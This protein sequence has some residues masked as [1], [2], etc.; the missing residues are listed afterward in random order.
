ML[1]LSCLLSTFGL[2]YNGIKRIRCYSRL[3][4]APLRDRSCASRTPANCTESNISLLVHGAQT[5]I[6]FPFLEQL[7][8]QK[9]YKIPCGSTLDRINSWY[10][11]QL[12]RAGFKDYL[13][14]SCARNLGAG[15]RYV[16]F[17][18]KVK[19]MIREALA[20]QTVVS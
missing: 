6:T 14:A 8:L 7:L 20:R 3:D 16:F 2:R 1:S 13:R 19:H 10:D 9:L 15:F 17:S 11:F 18:G 4:L 12:T 5:G